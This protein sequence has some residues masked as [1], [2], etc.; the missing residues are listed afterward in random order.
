MAEAVREAPA[1]GAAL[2]A[3]A[4]EP[5]GL[6]GLETA[7]PQA[8]SPGP[9][10]VEESAQAE[11]IREETVP[12]AAIEA[13]PIHQDAAP[14]DATEAEPN[15]EEAA[16]VDAIEV[17]PNREE[18]VPVEAIEAE[19]NREESVPVAAI[20]AEPVREEAAPVEAAEAE[21]ILEEPLREEAIPEKTLRDAPAQP[22]EGPPATPPPEAAAAPEPHRGPMLGFGPGITLR[23][24]QLGFQSIDELAHADP[25][26]LKEALG[27]IAQLIDIHAWVESARRMRG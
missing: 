2:E 6:E 12:V 10:G 22:A 3:P 26:Q 21:P 9:A 18:S 27:D 24:Q 17:E 11:P 15:R 23:L 25:Q 20:E 19:P 1:A 14:V 13:V 5:A 7:P 8:V 16:P 4:V